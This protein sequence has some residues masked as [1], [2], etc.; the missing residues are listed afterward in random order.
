MQDILYSKLYYITSDVR[1]KQGFTAK[2]QLSS[3]QGSNDFL[4]NDFA[5][6]ICLLVGFCYNATNLLKKISKQTMVITKYVP[7]Y[8]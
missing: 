2:M 4:I 3:N 8:N 5:N 7:Q 1:I 6:P